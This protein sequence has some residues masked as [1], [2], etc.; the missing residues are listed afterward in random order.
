MYLV[1]KVSLRLSERW[2]PLNGDRNL[3]GLLIDGARFEDGILTEL[4]VSA[5]GAV[6]A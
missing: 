6:A 3:M 2:R 1:F 4:P 5:E